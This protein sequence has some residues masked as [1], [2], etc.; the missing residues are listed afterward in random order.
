MTETKT[1]KEKAHEIQHATRQYNAQDGLKVFGHAVVSSLVDSTVACE[2]APCACGVGVEG[3]WTAKVRM[4]RTKES[5]GRVH[6]VSVSCACW[7]KVI[8]VLRR[9]EPWW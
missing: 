2:I 6:T 9:H 4:P 1:W 5:I 8:R 3:V 7:Q